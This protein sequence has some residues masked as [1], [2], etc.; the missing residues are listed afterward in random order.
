MGRSHHTAKVIGG[1]IQVLEEEGVFNVKYDA[2]KDGV[3]DLASLPTITRNKLE[4]PT[5]DVTFTYLAAI[6]K[7][8]THTPYGG[9]R[10]HGAWIITTDSFTDKGIQSDIKSQTRSF[11]MHRWGDENNWYECSHHYAGATTADHEIMKCVAGV[12]GTLATEAVD[13]NARSP[14]LGQV[15]GSTLK[16]DRGVDGIFEL[17]ATDTDLTSGSLGMHSTNSTWNDLIQAFLGAQLKA[18]LSPLKPALRVFEIDII[19]EGSEDDPIRPNFKQN[20]ASINGFKDKVPADTLKDYERY[21]IL[22]EKGFTDEEI[23]ALLGYIPQTHVDTLAITWGSFDYKGEATMLTCVLAD[24]PYQ[25]A[26]LE[27]ESWVNQKNLKIYKPPGNLTE[28]KDLYSQVKA[29]RPD[30]IA[31]VHNLAYQL[32]GDANLEPLAVAD[33]YDGFVQGIYDWKWLENVPGWEL[34]RTI[35]LWL[36]RLKIADVPAEEKEEHEKKL[37][38]I[39][40]L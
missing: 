4:Y 26:I 31:G 13:L 37:K 2:D 23:E 32:I 12:F 1:F 36:E 17:S 18:P 35:N 27:Q 6:N 21:L 40:K 9:A 3:V 5:V 11:F 39:L 8:R 38:Q 22:K 24:N 16:S 19:G 20:L 14:Y 33:F 34:E 7:L 30:I 29:D 25:G 15:S 10:E 28:A